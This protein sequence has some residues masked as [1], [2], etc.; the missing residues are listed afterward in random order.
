MNNIAGIWLIVVVGGPILLGLAML[1][2]RTQSNK[3]DRQVDPN[4]PAD[5]PARGMRPR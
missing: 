3:R 2:G 4:T 1:W 5:D